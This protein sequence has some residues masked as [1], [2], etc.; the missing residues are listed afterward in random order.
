MKNMRAIRR[1][2]YITMA[3]NL[4][5]MAAKLVVGY[6][7]GALS[8]VADGFDS[9]FDAAG[10]VI[11]LV[12]IYLASR[13]ADEEH[14]YGHRKF[15]T[16]TAI[17]ISLLLFITTWEL[18]Q[19]SWE[20]LRDPASMDLTINA[21][22]FGSL[23]LSI[24]VH[25]GVVVYELNAGRRLKS[26]VL[27]AD[28]MHTRADIFISVSVIVGL[29]AARLGYPIVD[30]LLA[31]GIAVLV[32]KIG[33]DIIRESSRT[34]LDGAVVPISEIERVVLGVR[35]VRSCHYVRSRGHEDAIYVDLHVEVA[36]EMTT[37]E[38]HALAHDVQH[39]LRV[40]IPSIQDVVVH[41]EPARGEASDQALIPALRGVAEELG[42]AIHDIAARSVGGG[43]HVDLHMTAD[44]S[45]TLEQAH[46][47]ADRFEE[48]ARARIEHLSEITTHLEPDD[49]ET[50]LPRDRMRS[51][52]DVQEAVRAALS[53]W[54]EPG[55][56]HEI[57]VHPVGDDWTVSV[58]CT[59][60]ST[61]SLREAHAASSRLEVHLRDVIPRLD[62][63]TVHTEPG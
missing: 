4:A 27:V 32:F 10:N 24:G 18:L 53:E 13:P 62:R 17:G 8:L 3:L 23:L 25:V 14:P 37:A 2:L 20:R 60:A 41:V 58:H 1:V 9:L 57:Q 43:F 35:D 19:T 12:G 49:E 59:L 11:G 22:S 7:T 36:P 5:A 39:R 34:L 38:S 63:V 42:I 21:W 31:L 26:D 40:E 29:I 16:L 52:H 45:L 30:P 61:V 47:M 15:E 48:L 55:Q 33:I 6:W 44:G 54:R 50:E 46:D 56:V 28:A 51:A